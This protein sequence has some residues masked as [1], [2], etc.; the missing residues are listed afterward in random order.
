MK[1]ALKNIRLANALQNGRARLSGLTHLRLSPLSAIALALLSAS[2]LGMALL[3]IY[4]IHGPLGPD[5]GAGVP[6][7]TPPSL[8]VVELDPP[9]PASADVESLSRPIFSK[10]R[11]PG[12]K[13]ATAPT[14]QTAAVPDA[15]P[16]LAVTAIVRDRK[17]SRAFVV[18]AEAPEGAWRKVGDVVDSWTVTTIAPTEVVLQS[19][20]QLSKVK[21][22]RE[23]ADAADA[24]AP[25]APPSG[26]EPPSPDGEPPK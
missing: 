16:G 4:A 25:G 23:A 9:K 12:P 20:G 22:Y 26:A 10:N 13:A 17:T 2:T 1:T 21:L 7:W 8:A 5:S 11:K 15:P 24:A 14:A 19:G 18:S 3:A 6:D